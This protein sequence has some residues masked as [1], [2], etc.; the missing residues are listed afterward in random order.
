MDV[1]ENP[2]DQLAARATL[3]IPNAELFDVDK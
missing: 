3:V 2:A 1:A